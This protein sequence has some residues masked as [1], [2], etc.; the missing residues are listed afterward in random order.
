[1]VQCTGEAKYVSDVD[2][3]PQMLHAA[4]T[5]T[6]QGNASIYKV[7]TTDALVR[8]SSAVHAENEQCLFGLNFKLKS[9]V[10]SYLINCEL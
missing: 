10:F 3:G 4:L 5:L 2:S 7:D 6:A 8:I 9:N 1:M